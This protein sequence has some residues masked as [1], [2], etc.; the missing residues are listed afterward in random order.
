MGKFYLQNP[1]RCTDLYGV[2]LDNVS[3]YFHWVSY[4]GLLCDNRDDFDQMDVK[5]DKIASSYETS[6]S[7]DSELDTVLVSSSDLSIDSVLNSMAE[8]THNN[9]FIAKAIIYFKVGRLNFR[10]AIVAA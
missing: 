1:S 2:L 9:S 10:S 8:G 7:Y 6:S 3:K 5:I 4:L